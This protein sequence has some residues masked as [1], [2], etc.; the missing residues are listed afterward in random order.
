MHFIKRGD[1]F[2]IAID[3]FLWSKFDSSKVSLNFLIFLYDFDDEMQSL[4]HKFERILLIKKAVDLIMA[5]I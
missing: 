2:S 3:D 5:L 1:D 4:H